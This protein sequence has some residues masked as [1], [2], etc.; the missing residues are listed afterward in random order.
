MIA[1]SESC[2]HFLFDSDVNVVWNN[3]A[4]YCELGHFRLLFVFPFL[5]RALN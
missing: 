3:R 4:D 2:D 5:L 1:D